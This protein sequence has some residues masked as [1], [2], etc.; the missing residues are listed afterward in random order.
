VWFVR[1]AAIDLS[2]FRPVTNDEGELLEVSYTL[3]NQGVLGSPMYAGFFGADSHHLWTL[4]VQHAV[5]AA[6]FKIFGAGIAQARSAS[7]LAA[8]ATLWCVG[9]LALRW[10]GLAAALLSEVL[11][12]VWRSNL[13]QGTTGLPLLD[14]ARVARY[15]VLAVA[16]GSLALLALTQGA[17]RSGG[18]AAGASASL[19]ALSQFFGAAALPV[20]LLASRQRHAWVVLGAATVGMPW[21]V[22]TAAYREDLAG[23]LTVYG[24]RGE[25]LR[26]RFYVDNLLTEPSRYAGVLDHASTWLVLG[27]GPALVWLAWRCARVSR[28]GDRLLG[29]SLLCSLALLSMLDATKTPLY[30]ILLVPGVCMVLAASWSAVLHRFWRHRAWW[31]AATGVM[32]AP[33]VADGLQA[34]RLDRAESA[35]VTA[36]AQVG[37]RIEAAVTGDGVVLG[38]ERWWWAVHEHQYISL[39]SLWFQWTSQNGST[40]F[41]ELANRWQPRRLIVNNNVRDDIRAFPPELQEQFWAF[42]D[43]CARMVTQ[44]DDPTYFDIRVYDVVGCYAGPS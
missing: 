20:V 44:I 5:D 13:T 26:P 18:L 4:P 1:A 27:F 28:V 16:F 22:Y 31:L 10:Y 2:N 8:L 9:W 39:R 30:A 7:V 40:S 12:T 3:A 6:A 15:D 25:F 14:V 42:V 19:A 38:P 37:Q 41:N 36:Y 32:L 33:V 43:Q 23:Q 35:Q 11:L 29:L 24:A 34:Y 21:L 17:G